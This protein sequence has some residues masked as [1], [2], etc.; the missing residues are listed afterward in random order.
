[1]NVC[2]L[3]LVLRNLDCF[4]LSLSLSISACLSLPVYL[5]LSI[6]V[7]LCLSISVYLCL[8]ISV[9]LRLSISAYLYLSI[10]VYLCLSLVSHMV[11]MNLSIHL[12]FSSPSGVVYRGRFKVK[13]LIISQVP[14][15]L[16]NEEDDDIYIEFPIRLSFSSKN[17]AGEEVW[18]GDTP[19]DIPLRRIGP[20]STDVFCTYTGP[21]DGL[22]HIEKLKNPDFEDDK[23]MYILGSKNWNLKNRKAYGIA[24]SLYDQ[25]PINGKISGDPIA[26]AFAISARMNNALLVIAD[27]V[28]WGEK[29]K[30]AARCAVYGCMENMYK[31]LF[32]DNKSIRTTQEAMQ[33][34]LESFFAAHEVILEHEGGL[35]TLCAALVLPLAY[36]KQFAVLVVNVGDSL[37]FVFSKFHGI[38]EIT[39]G[40]HDLT[41]ERDIRDAG[42]ALGPVD[43]GKNPELH[44]M[45]C[46]M[47]LVDPGD[48]VFLTTDGISDNFDPVVTK[49]ALSRRLS[50]P[51]ISTTDANNVSAPRRVVNNYKPEMEPE[52]RHRYSVREMERVIHEFELDTESS[53]SAQE[54]CGALLQHVLKLT[55]GKRKVLEDPNLYGKKLKSKERKRRDSLI[56]DKMHQAAGKL[57]HAS[58]VA[59]EV[60]HYHGNQDEN[61]ELEEDEEDYPEPMSPINPSGP[62]P[63]AREISFETSL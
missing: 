56:T 29:S 16:F 60:G 57:D 25:H 15:A 45:T 53:V 52:E 35:T 47:T 10:S 58:I 13:P 36:R 63:L 26:D 5:C 8:S 38:R 33:H 50:E 40:S 49:I 34:L 1:M 46:S 51:V 18:Y 44:N 37:A 59:Y 62:A 11:S 12:V 4:N 19:K 14:L 54:F 61:Y 39:V 43:A 28:N 32:R 42:G 22:L 2:T 3:Y 41:S 55:D 48:I 24:M 20:L 21:D 23:T 9:Y 7:Y 6:S 17:K 27:G 30:L 31:K